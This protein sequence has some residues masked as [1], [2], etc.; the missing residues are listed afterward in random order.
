VVVVEEAT[1]SSF[2]ALILINF[3]ASLTEFAAKP[4]KKHHFP[5]IL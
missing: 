3:A 4:V 2:I 5:Q 1:F